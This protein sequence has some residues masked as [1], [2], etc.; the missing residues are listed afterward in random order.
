M[1]AILVAPGK[2]F[3]FD[4]G[5]EVGRPDPQPLDLEDHRS[6]QEL[7]VGAR[8]LDRPQDVEATQAGLQQVDAVGGEPRSVRA[9]R[10]TGRVRAAR[11]GLVEEAEE[12]S[13]FASVKLGT[14]SRS[15]VVYPAPCKIAATLSTTT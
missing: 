5:L 8:R 12:T 6:R 11:I 2:L 7:F 15:S 13:R 10:A 14:M 4:Q 1:Q 3:G 9:N